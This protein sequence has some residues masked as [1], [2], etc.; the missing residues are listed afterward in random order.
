MRQIPWFLVSWPGYPCIYYGTEQGFDGAGP[1]DS[2]VRECMFG[3]GWG[4]FNST[5]GHFFN[6]Q[7]QIYQQIAA[8]TRIRQQQSTLRYGRQYFRETSSDGINFTHPVDGL[9]F[10]AYSRIL[11]TEEVLVVL[12]LENRMRRDWITIDYK[13]SS[14]GTMMLDL[15]DP[16]RQCLVEEVNARARVQVEL[17]AHGVAI[18]KCR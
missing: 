10:L 5:G 17:P 11:D 8:I 4:A 6:D 15:L 7:H 3:G 9:C 14:P 16:G 2:Y 18:L 1:D 12:N 13:L